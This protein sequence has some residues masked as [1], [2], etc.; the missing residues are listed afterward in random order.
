MVFV[1]AF[2]LYVE[3]AAGVVG[4]RFEEM[5]EHFGGHIAYFL[6]PEIGVPY[7]PGSSAEIDGHLRQT[8][9]HRQEKPIAFNP[10]FRCESPVE[11]FTQRN[12]G[13]FDGMVLIDLQVAFHL[14]REV[15]R[16]VAR[17]LFEHVVEESEARGNTAFAR[18]VEVDGNEYRGFR[19]M[20]FYR[21]L[22]RFRFQETINLAPVGGG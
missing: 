15:D 12:G 20:A 18:S 16:S 4:K 21:C 9:V 19:R 11:R 8:I 3:V 7:Q 13:I 2:G 1:I 14:H 22:S 5:Q 10:F 17:N 6:A